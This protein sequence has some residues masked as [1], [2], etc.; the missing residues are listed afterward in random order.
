MS[1]FLFSKKIN[2]TSIA[3]VIGMADSFVE[4]KKNPVIYPSIYSGSSTY[5]FSAIKLHNPI[6]P[7]KKK[8]KD[9]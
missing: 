8:K 7:A 5:N 3:M 1:Y 9:K 2:I 6:K 4:R